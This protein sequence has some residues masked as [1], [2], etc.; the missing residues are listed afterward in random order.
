TGIAARVAMRLVA[1]GAADGIGQLPQFTI[2]GTVAIISSGAIAGLP[3]GGVY[4]LIERRLPR[5]GRAHGI[6]FA[7]LVL[8]FFGRLFLPNEEIFSQGRFVLFTLLFPI[9]G[10]A[11]GVALPVAEGLVP[12]MP[13]AVTRVLVTLAA[14]AG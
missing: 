13:N 10:L 4:A 14:G 8:V 3:F 7:A 1:I 11:I 6:W 2:E 9:Y 5:P 12:R